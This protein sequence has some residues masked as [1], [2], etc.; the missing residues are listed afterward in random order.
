MI[1]VW[2]FWHLIIFTSKNYTIIA[3]Y[4]VFCSFINLISVESYKD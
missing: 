3:E 2:S 4:L 1:L